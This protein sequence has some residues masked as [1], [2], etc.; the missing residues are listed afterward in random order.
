VTPAELRALLKR[1]GLSQIEAALLLGVDVRTM[2]RW[3][4]AEREMPEPAV[5]LLWACEHYPG[6]QAGLAGWSRSA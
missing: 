1:L 2:R 6:V 3:M 4:M 5:R